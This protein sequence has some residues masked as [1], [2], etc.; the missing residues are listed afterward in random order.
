MNTLGEGS[1][2]DPKLSWMELDSG[3]TLGEA[4]SGTDE[5][6]VLPRIELQATALPFVCR[7]LQSRTREVKFAD[8]IGLLWR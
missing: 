7:Q 1:I 2:L 3:E 5:A 6:S 4:P 8:F